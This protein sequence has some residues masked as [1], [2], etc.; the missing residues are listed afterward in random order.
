MA[1]EQGLGTNDLAANDGTG[2]I[3]APSISAA[4]NLT[5]FNT[6]LS[7]VY[8]SE[9]TGTKILV[10]PTDEPKGGMKLTEILA[11]VNNMINKFTGSSSKVSEDDIKKT[12]NDFGLSSFES[13]RI[14]LRQV[15]FYYETATKNLEYALSIRITDDIKPG[16]ELSKLFTVKSLSF[17]IWS[18]K[19]QKILD[20]MQL[21]DIS[22]LLSA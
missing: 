3:V 21:G 8:Q 19:R 10:I 6:D 1:D 4:I 11:E 12:L 20:R 7:A 17:S 22:A 9:T 13:I 2:A 5:L 18:T 16:E 14:E 15:F